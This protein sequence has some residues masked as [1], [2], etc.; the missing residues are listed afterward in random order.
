MLLEPE[1]A[2]HDLSVINR[3]LCDMHAWYRRNIP[4]PQLQPVISWMRTQPP[5]YGQLCGCTTQ[6]VSPDIYRE[7][8]WPLDDA[9]LAVYPHGGMI[10]LCGSHTHL[11]PEFRNMPHLHAVQLNDRAARDLELYFNGLRNDQILYLNPCK[12]MTVEEG[13]R[14]TGGKRL[15]IADTI[16]KLIAAN[17]E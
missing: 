12:E 14:I 6:L 1:K 8:I 3:L 9:L 2:S 5:G 10:H 16:R 13:V 15:V 7:M 17:G 11:I 4:A